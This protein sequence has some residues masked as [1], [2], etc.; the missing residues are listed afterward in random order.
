MTRAYSGLIIALLVAGT[1]TA[2]RAQPAADDAIAPHLFPP[3]LIMKYQREMGLDEGQTKAIKQEIQQAQTRFTDFQ[4][5]MQ[6][7]SQKLVQLLQG[8]PV[9]EAAVLAQA[10]RLMALEREVKRVQL[11]LLVRLKNLLKEDQQRTLTELR[12]RAG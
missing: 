7:E 9:N 3:E 5:D 1:V 8:R 4:W 6:G 2:V 12:R 10:D 11:S